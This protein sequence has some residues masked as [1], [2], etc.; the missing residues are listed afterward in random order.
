MGGHLTTANTVPS[1]LVHLLPPLFIVNVLEHARSW[2]TS[3]VLELLAAASSIDLI[4]STNRRVGRFVIAFQCSPR[5]EPDKVYHRMTLGVAVCVC[6]MVICQEHVN[7]QWM[8]LVLFVT[9]QCDSKFLARTHTHTH[10]P[11]NQFVANYCCHWFAF[12]FI[13]TFISNN[14]PS[15]NCLFHIAATVI[16]LAAAAVYTCKAAAFAQPNL[17]MLTL[18]PAAVAQ[19]V[20]PPLISLCLLRRKA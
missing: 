11:V 17:S 2:S 15:I 12:L 3:I 5:F 10:T 1:F 14:S 7:V 9:A 6:K 16:E 20:M 4:F 8:T 18:F 13:I 19:A